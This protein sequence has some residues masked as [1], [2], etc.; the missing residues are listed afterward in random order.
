MGPD[1]SIYP[2]FRRKTLGG[3]NVG[4][5]TLGGETS[6]GEF[7]TKISGRNVRR[8]KFRR[9]MSG[10]TASGRRN[11]LAAGA[12]VTTTASAPRSGRC[13]PLESSRADRECGVFTAVRR[14]AWW[15]EVFRLWRRGCCGV[16]LFWGVR[17]RFQRAG[18]VRGGAVDVVRLVGRLRGVGGSVWCTGCGM[19][20][21]ATAPRRLSPRERA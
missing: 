16:G 7:P 13:G 17:V 12:C 19:S 1:R 5:K 18:A 20:R 11:S 6:G 15:W 21:A 14:V 9:W 2:P 10:A 4:E 8:R 3:E